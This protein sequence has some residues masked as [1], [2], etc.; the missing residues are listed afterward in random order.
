MYEHNHLYYKQL[1]TDSSAW[2]SLNMQSDFVPLPQCVGFIITIMSY[3]CL[4]IG[5]KY[6]LLVPGGKLHYIRG[7]KRTNLSSIL[8]Y[9]EPKMVVWPN[10]TIGLGESNLHGPKY[11]SYSTKLNAYYVC[12]SDHTQLHLDYHLLLNKKK[13]SYPY[14]WSKTA[15]YAL[16]L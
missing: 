12:T 10:S 6:K 5:S 9:S 4:H 2:L 1:F 13:A 14:V 3:L 11:G 7:N 8:I 16:S 15:Q